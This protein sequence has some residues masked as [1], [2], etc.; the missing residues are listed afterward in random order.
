M[1]KKTW[2]IYVH[3]NIFPENENQE[4]KR[5]KNLW[6]MKKKVENFRKIKTAKI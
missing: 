5:K 6:E 4:S 2:K 1:G 3:T